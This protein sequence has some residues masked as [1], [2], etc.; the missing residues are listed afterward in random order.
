[1]RFRL[2]TLTFVLCAAGAASAQTTHAP[3]LTSAPFLGKIS[4]GGAINYSLDRKPGNQTVTISGSPATVH[5]VGTASQREYTATVHQS[6]LKAGR[7]YR[8][9]ITALARDGK[10]KLTFRRTL[11]MHRS[12]NRPQ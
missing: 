8:V 2:L 3:R 6:K 12:L 10:S 9:V 5:T 1:M 4:G 7:S 11:Y